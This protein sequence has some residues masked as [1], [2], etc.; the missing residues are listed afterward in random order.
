MAPKFRAWLKEEKRM[1]DV[2][3]MTFID[4]EVYLISDV[5]GFYAYDEFELMQSTGLRDKN[6]REIYEG[7]IV[8][9]KYGVNTFTEV[10]TYDKDFAGFGLVDDDGYGSTVFTFGELAEDVDFSSLEVAG[11][12]YENP[13]LLK[14]K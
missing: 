1:T 2:H 3:E 12:I 6:G 5:T 11:N 14:G 10:V 9:Y 7:D 4:G 8:K 13:E